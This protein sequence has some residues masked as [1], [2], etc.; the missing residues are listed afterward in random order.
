MPQIFGSRK[1][2]SCKQKYDWIGRLDNSLDEQMQNQLLINSNLQR[3]R[4]SQRTCGGFISHVR[5]T[6]CNY[7]DDFEFGK[8][9]LL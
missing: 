6:Y 2:P 5:C 8:K 7:P 1:C 4:F 9:L 3:A